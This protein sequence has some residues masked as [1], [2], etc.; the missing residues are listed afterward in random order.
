MRNKNG[1]SINSRLMLFAAVLFGIC[2]VASLTHAVNPPANL[3]GKVEV[4][5]NGSDYAFGAWSAKWWQWALSIPLYTDAGEPNHPLFDGEDCSVGQ[6][7]HVWFLGGRFCETGKECPLPGTVVRSCT[8]P[9]G[10][11]LFIP[12]VNAEDSLLEET[13]LGGSNLTIESMRTFL[14]GVLETVTNLEL[15]VDGIPVQNLKEDFRVKSPVFNFRLP[16]P[17]YNGDKPNNVFTAIESGNY[18]A[19]T[20]YHQAVGDGFYV[21]LKPLPVGPHTIDFSGTFPN[22]PGPEDDFIISMI[23][24][25]TVE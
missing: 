23:Y 15:K 3:A 9:K 19:G 1:F 6:S 11:A 7:G 5:K 17:L 13:E 20:Y 18:P 8:I 10:T 25:I 14:A 24:N 21:M 4:I 16:E 2:S 22:G 12:I